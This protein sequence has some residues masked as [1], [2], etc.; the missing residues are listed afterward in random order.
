MTTLPNSPLTNTA[1]KGPK[2]RATLL[3]VGLLMTMVVGTVATNVKSSLAA[4]S[5]WY[6]GANQYSSIINCFSIIQGNPYPESGVAVSV[7][8]YADPSTNS[9]APNTVYYVHVV[10]T[11]LG[12]SCAGQSVDVNVSLPASTSFAI[13]PA[14]KVVCAYDGVPFPD[15]Q[16]PQSL[17]SSNGNAFLPGGGAGF[18]RVPSPDN[19]NLNLWGVPTGHFLT[20]AIPVTTTTAIS[21]STLAGAVKV[22]DGNSSPTLV[23]TQGVYVFDST[24]AIVQSPAGTAFGGVSWPTTIRSETYLYPNGQGGQGYF[25]L[26]TSPGGPVVYTDGPAAVPAGSTSGYIVWADW[27]PYAPASLAPNTT[28]YWRFRFVSATTGTYVGAVQSFKTPLANQSVVGTGTPASCTGAA[29]ATALA[30]ASQNITFNCGQGL[31]TINMQSTINLA[32]TRVINGENRITLQAPAGSRHFSIASG[33]PTVRG[34]TLTGGNTST[35]GGAVL[36]TGGSPTFWQMRMT[37]NSSATSGGAV[38]VQNNASLNLSS[39]T[40]ANN[41]A[42]PGG[43]GAVS[44]TGGGYLDMRFSS[45]NNNTTTG[46]GGALLFSGADVTAF[47]SSITG[48]TAGS[49]SYGGAMA[50]DAGTLNVTYSTVSGNRAGSGGGLEQRPSAGYMFIAGST[51]AANTSSTVGRPAGIVGASAAGGQVVG[52]IVAGNTNNSAAANCAT[53]NTLRTFVST[54]YNMDDGTSCGF[55][56]PSDRSST[57][58]QLLPLGS[59]DGGRLRHALSAGSP[60]IDHNSSGYCS[61]V[62]NSISAT[63]VDGDGNGS[64]ICDIGD[65]EYIPETT[66]PVVNAASRAGADPVTAA[67]TQW[68]VVFSEAVLGVDVSDFN[69][70]ANGVT[71]ASIASISPNGPG[72][73]F[74]VTANA[75]NNNGT[76]RLNVID[77]NS[78]HDIAGN[79]LAGAGNGAF[80]GEVYTVTRP[81]GGGGTGGGGNGFVAVAPARLLD[82][83]VG[84]STVDGLFVGGGMSGPNSV[85]EL[86][87]GGRPGVPGD[88]SAVVLNVTAAGATGAGYVT[89]FPCGQ[90]PPNSSNLNTTPGGTVPNAVTVKVGAGGKVCLF[91]SVGV[92][93]H[94]LVDVNGYFPAGG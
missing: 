57:N 81:A 30:S 63:P 26:M 53:Q 64:Q 61:I 13:S 45:L 37:G 7:G 54:G 58:P 73:V 68:T 22:F 9:P 77:D 69:L 8:F 56:A 39:V 71:G 18:Y 41:S 51:V 19:A 83:R 75:G 32:G 55:A 80:A 62:G 40:L 66:P 47:L 28:Y 15:S 76:L 14:N 16:C 50:V 34:V 42:G 86:Q 94:L 60:A 20:F 59:W 91:T 1:G 79:A 74:T 87:V 84:G 27:T 70:T 10:V 31:A 6:D 48:N 36:V 33:T 21:N 24:P 92:S 65:Y 43:G 12:N 11:G 25:E 49:S 23:A 46:P 5:S 35:C 72:T 29:L 78:I 52:T 67:T 93:T 17:P 3:A 44:H 4:G 2:L 85:V 88:V 38:C 89:V 90:A 82:S